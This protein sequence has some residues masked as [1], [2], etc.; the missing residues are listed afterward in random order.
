MFQPTLLFVALLSILCAGIY[1][2]VGRV[3]TRRRSTTAD[4]R[5]AWRL[6]VAWWYALATATLLGATQNFLGALGITGLPLFT[7]I[8]LLNLLATCI[9]LFS[10]MFYLVYLFTGNRNFLAPLAIFYILYFALLIYYIQVRDPIDVTVERWKTALVYQNQTSGPFFVLILLL[11]VFPQIIGSLAYFMLYF[12]VKLASQKYRILLVS[13]SIIIWFLSAFLASI[14]SFGQS[15][16]WQI[17]SRLIG[18]AAAFAILLAYQPPVW[19]KQ[20][21]GVRSLSEENS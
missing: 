12:R 21:F 10:L 16:L 7:T 9:A 15:D 4:A 14:T 20:R 6:F 17:L 1:Y 8:T 18:L 13:W 19:I 5:L 11:L 2:Y 3:L